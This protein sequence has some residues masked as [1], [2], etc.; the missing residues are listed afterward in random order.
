[1]MVSTIDLAGEFGGGD[2][3]T[4]EQ[5]KLTSGGGTGLLSVSS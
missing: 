3:K 5:V 4:R 2:G 1:M